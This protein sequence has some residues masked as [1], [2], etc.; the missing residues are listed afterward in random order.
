MIKLTS[1][2]KNIIK[3]GNNPQRKLVR[4]LKDKIGKII[5]IHNKLLRDIQKQLDVKYGIKRII[6]WREEYK[7]RVFKMH[8]KLRDQQLYVAIQKPHGNSKP[9]TIID[10]HTKNTKESKNYT[11]VSHQITREE[12]KR[13]RKET[14]RRTKT[15]PKQLPKW[16]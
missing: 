1:K 8:L 4:I 16:Q 7:C 15:N 5:Y 11:K 6:V 9:K 10:I 12:N 2:V 3:V 13:R 14:K